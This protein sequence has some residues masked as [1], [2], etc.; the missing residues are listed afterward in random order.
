MIEHNL[1]KAHSILHVRPLSALREE[2][3]AQLA[4]VVDPFIET[5]GDLAG[6]IVEVTAFPGW[7]SLGAMAA[8][9][10]FVRDHHRRIKKVAVVTDAA[11]GNL[12]EALASHFVAAKIAHFPAAHI[13]AAR[14][15][16]TGGMPS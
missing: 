4:R 13:E 11:L 10:R 7:D 3:F 5:T 9:F 15:W 8:H 16:I 1:D 6:L 12:A 14:Q 2:D